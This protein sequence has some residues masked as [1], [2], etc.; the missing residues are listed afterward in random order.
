M[1]IVTFYSYKGGVGRTMALV[2]TAAA[3]TQQ[4]KRVLAV[5]FDLEAPGLPS[6]GTFHGA[7][8]KRGLVDYV[9]EYMA[10]NEAPDVSD[11]IVECEPGKLWLMSAG[12]YRSETY[13]AKLAAIDWQELYE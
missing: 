13:S 5:D 4:G 3:L 6:Y 12:D 9:T 8:S 2:N 10:H 7:D 1:Y 11:Y